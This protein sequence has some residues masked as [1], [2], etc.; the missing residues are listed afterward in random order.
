MKIR[1]SFLGKEIFCLEAERDGVVEEDDLAV[2]GQVPSKVGGGENHNF[3][4]DPNPLIPG[5]DRDYDSW[6]DRPFGFSRRKG[7]ISG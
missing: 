2:S 1:F 3:D 6:A 7:N 5:L 4:R